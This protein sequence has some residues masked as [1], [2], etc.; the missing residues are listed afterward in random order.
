[1]N[2]LSAIVKQRTDTLREEG[3]DMVSFSDQIETVIGVSPKEAEE[4]RGLLFDIPGFT[5]SSRCG[6]IQGKWRTLWTALPCGGDGSSAGYSNNADNV[7]AGWDYRPDGT[8]TTFCPPKC[9]REKIL[10]LLSGVRDNKVELSPRESG[11]SQQRK[12]AT[13]E[14]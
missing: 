3:C 2:P 4:A 12:K 7:P 14:A 1:M 9:V 8:H 5:M 13:N 10:S 11:R 6:F